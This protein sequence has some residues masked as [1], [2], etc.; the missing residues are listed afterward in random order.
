MKTHRDLFIIR[1]DIGSI[2]K[3]EVGG[4]IIEIAAECNMD[5]R[6]NSDQIGVIEAAPEGHEYFKKGDTVLTHYLA[7]G[8]DKSFEYEGVVYHRVPLNLIFL[9]INDDNTFDM[10]DKVYVCEEIVVDAPKSPSG[11]LLTPFDDKREP[12]RLRALHVPKFNR[13]IAVGD[14]LISQ[15]D[16]Q[17]TFTYD[18]KKYIQINYDHILATYE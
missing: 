8:S 16:Y 7:S 18:K 9:R 10:N 12:M 17:Y 11:I 1:Y 3:V 15:D 14:K 13:G 6:G 2:R 4:V 5:I